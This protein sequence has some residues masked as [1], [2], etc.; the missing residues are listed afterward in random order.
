MAQRN[1]KVWWA[2][3]IGAAAVGAYFLF[4]KKAQAADDL[5]DD[6][7]LDQ[8]R[9]KLMPAFRAAAKKHSVPLSWLLA[10]AHRESKFKNVR[11]KPG[12][13]DD[14]RGGSWGPMQMSSAT[15]KDLGFKPS[16]SLADRGAAIVADPATGIDL[17]AHYVAR[18]IK[19]FGQDAAKVA[20][21]Y[22]AGPGAVQRD[23]IPAST[24]D[25]Y[26]PAVLKLEQ[27][28]SSVA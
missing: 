2:V 24:R 26:V 8:R 20:A 25:R 28:Y 14:R 18:L 4:R 19:R 5:P 23:H 27:K 11:S 7:G 1:K 9:E 16:D 13:S 22:N 17:G 10:I 15:A 6:P 21:G 3:G 12:A